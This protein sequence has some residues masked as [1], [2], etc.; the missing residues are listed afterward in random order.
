MP[1]SVWKGAISFGLVTIPIRLFPA[2]RSERT[3]FHQI[4]K[5]CHTRLRQPL[6][7]PHCQRIVNRDEVVRGYEYEPGQ[8]VLIDD[9][10]IKKIT[11]RTSSS[12]EIQAFVK[13]EQIDPIYFNSSYLAVP[14]KENEKPYAL[15][16]KALKDSQRVGIAKVT[17]HMREYVVA[18]RPRDQGLTL[19][20]MYFANEIRKVESYGKIDKAVKLRPREVKLAE[21]LVESLSEDF[22]PRQY[23]DTFQENLRDLI[24]AKR[25]G[26]TIVEETSP[27][28]A[29]VIDMMEALKRSVE[30]R[31]SGKKEVRKARPPHREAH[32]RL[33]S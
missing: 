16:L 30:A 31:G 4:H 18:I 1:G 17:M 33:A 14:E 28:R 27:R 20:T 7:C 22:D 3:R 19:H 5:K 13:E 2:A 26:K 29:P 9:S 32:R 25:K 10:E 8:Y 15:L 21:E 24:A 23:H 12:M 6:Y 11:P